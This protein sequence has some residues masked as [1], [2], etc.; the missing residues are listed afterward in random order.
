[1]P[2]VAPIEPPTVIHDLMHKREFARVIKAIDPP[3]GGARGAYPFFAACIETNGPM[4]GDKIHDP[5]WVCSGSDDEISLDAFYGLIQTHA[6]TEL[7]I[8]PKVEDTT[9]TTSPQ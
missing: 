5:N 2:D 9:S 6:A 1:L 7:P 8:S 4:Y 3:A